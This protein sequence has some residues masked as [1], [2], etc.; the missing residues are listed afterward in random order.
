MIR[1]LL[2]VA[3]MGATLT[4]GCG[5]EPTDTPPVESRGQ[6]L[7][8]S[9]PAE[10]QEVA[11]QS[12]DSLTCDTACWTHCSSNGVGWTKVYKVTDGNKGNC[13]GRAYAFCYR[14]SHGYDHACMH[15]GCS[16]FFC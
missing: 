14:L 2:A 12:E 13:V 3:V 9:T 5:V 1:N 8:A 7:I 10:A 4:I 16:S 6:A 15:W 11:V